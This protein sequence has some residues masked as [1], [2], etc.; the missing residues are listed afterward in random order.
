M[1]NQKLRVYVDTSVFGGTQD[2]EYS[3]PSKHFFDLVKQGKILVLTS[4]ITLDE[5]DGAPEAVKN[6]FSTL[7]HGSIE[8]VEVNDEVEKLAQAY[9]DAGILGDSCRADAGHVAAATIA[10]ADIIISWNFKHIVNYDRI[11]KYN[12]VNSLNGYR[13]I[14]IYSPLEMAYDNETQDI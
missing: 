13:P 12:G 6:V 8:E 10:R 2:D 7:P 1:S 11:H 4:Q 3:L 9:I 14:E 5:L